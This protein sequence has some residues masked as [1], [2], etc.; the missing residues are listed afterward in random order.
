MA[1]SGCFEVDIGNISPVYGASIP[2]VLGATEIASPHATRAD[3]AARASIARHAFR[4]KM[5]RQHIFRHLANGMGSGASKSS[6]PSQTLPRYASTKDPA[7]N[8]QPAQN[9]RVAA[10]DP[11]KVSDQAVKQPPVTVPQ[12]PAPTQHLQPPVAVIRETSESPERD[13]PHFEAKHQAIPLESPPTPA[14]QVDDEEAPANKSAVT[15]GIISQTKADEI[16]HVYAEHIFKSADEDHDGYLNES[17]FCILAQAPTLGLDISD[18]E[19]VSMMTDGCHDPT[20]GVSMSEFIPILKDLMIRHC[21]AKQDADSSDHWKWF[22]MLFESDADLLP[23]YYNTID[24]V[25]TYDK[26]SGVS[27]AETKV[28]AFENVTLLDGTVRLHV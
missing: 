19:A 1:V 4:K 3:R 17:E 13:P 27:R 9:N 7:D 2:D 10:Q 15:N 21:T 20:V 6:K 14:E 22:T 28:Q 18:E 8:I 25:M 24:D 23:V 11:P 5:P 16:Y 12:Q 26:P